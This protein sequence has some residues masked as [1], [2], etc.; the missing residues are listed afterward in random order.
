MV[1]INLVTFCFLIFGK[2]DSISKAAGDGSCGIWLLREEIG[3]KRLHFS[4]SLRDWTCS[5]EGH[6]HEGGEGQRYRLS[7]LF[8][9]PFRLTEVAL[10]G[11]L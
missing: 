7:A 5:A 11:N 10:L 8:P 3:K 2:L 4:S 9:Y 1:I 6:E